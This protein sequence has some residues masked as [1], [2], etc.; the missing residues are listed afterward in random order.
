[1]AVKGCRD[2]ES[3]EGERGEGERG[4][5]LSRGERKREG[6]ENKGERGGEGGGRG[7]RGS[8][9]VSAVSRRSW[10]VLWLVSLICCSSAR[11]VAREI[12]N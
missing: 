5:W 7:G 10:C 12:S 6:A 11:A 4:G 3:K 1:M 2:R 9:T 8:H